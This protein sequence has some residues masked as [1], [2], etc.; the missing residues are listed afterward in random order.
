MPDPGLAPFLGETC[1]VFDGGD[2]IPSRQE[3]SRTDPMGH[4]FLSVDEMWV[5]VLDK[6]CL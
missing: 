5:E 3:G 4:S 2:I 6:I 1:P